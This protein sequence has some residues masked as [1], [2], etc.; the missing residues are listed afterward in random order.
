[1]NK[2]RFIV[3]LLVVIL[4]PLSGCVSDGS[5]GVQGEQGLQG[6]QGIQGE[7]GAD[8]LDGTNGLNGTDGQDGADGQAGA[9]GKNSLISTFDVA[10]G[11]QCENGGIGILIGLDE[12]ENGMLTSN[13]V[14]ET[15][16]VC[17][18]EDG[19]STSAEGSSSPSLLHAVTTLGKSS[20]CPAGGKI[21]LFG[22]DNGDDQGIAGNGI[23]EP[24][25]VDEKTTYCST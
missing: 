2:Q 4:L 8:G 3:V 24:G 21:M 20:G 16:F 18:G 23:L 10:P 1:M 5:D 7:N 9:D 15:T 22:L 17:N 11:I 14:Y 13:E 19:A 12:N 25:E 6:E